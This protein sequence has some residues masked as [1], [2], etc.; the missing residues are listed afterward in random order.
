MVLCGSVTTE[1]TEQGKK[2]LDPFHPSFRVKR[3]K[4]KR[5][6]DFRDDLFLDIIQSSKQG[7]ISFKVDFNLL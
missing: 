7:L 2:D 6:D 5:L 1:P 3:I 4:D